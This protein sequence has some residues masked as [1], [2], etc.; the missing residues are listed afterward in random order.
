[1]LRSV[2][3]SA[4]RDAIDFFR[5]QNFY[6]PP[7]AY[8]TPDDWLQKG[9]EAAEI[10]QNGLGWDITDYGLDN[11][12]RYG[13]LLFTLRNGSPSE[14][15]QGKGKPY[16]EKIMIAEVGQE[17]QMHT[18]WKKVED[19]INRAGGSLAI[20]LFN[21]SAEDELAKSDVTF[22]MDGIRRTIPAGEVVRLIPGESITLHPRL[23]HKFWAEGSRVM[24]GE[25]STINDD[26]NDNHFYQPFGSGRF[27]EIVEDEP[28]LYLLFSEY[29]NF[30]NPEGILDQA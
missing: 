9:S 12:Q 30:W 18:H 26:T 16:C 1:M 17:H 28:P 2:V 11:F 25:V 27:S 10:V 19:I 21:A 14:W 5:A 4:L 20:R 29:K 6:L 23:F 8:W 13:L 7:F 15:R 3:N 22:T 24:M